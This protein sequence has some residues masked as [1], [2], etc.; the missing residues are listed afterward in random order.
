MQ[1]YICPTG[2]TI[3]IRNHKHKPMPHG[4]HCLWSY[5]VPNSTQGYYIP[6]GH[7]RATK[8]LWHIC[9]FTTDEQIIEVS[10]IGRVLSL[11]RKMNSDYVVLDAGYFMPNTIIK[12]S[13]DGKLS[14]LSDDTNPLFEMN[15]VMSVGLN[16]LND[17]INQ[18]LNRYRLYRENEVIR[19]T[20]TQQ[21]IIDRLKAEVDMLQNEIRLL[22][23]EKIALEQ[24]ASPQK[25]SRSDI[26]AQ[27]AL[28]AN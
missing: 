19:E 6:S 1:D 27:L 3:W 21:A 5:N 13:A 17:N 2:S 20:R 23:E 15:N 14:G 12:V 7:D 11:D 16:A 22:K 10:Q 28:D 4:K 24:I 8:S 26:F 25:R 9:W 18:I